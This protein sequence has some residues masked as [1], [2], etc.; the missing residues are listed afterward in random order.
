MLWSKLADNGIPGEIRNIFVYWDAKQTGLKGPS[1]FP[2]SIG[3]VCGK[4]G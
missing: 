2:K 4:G 1:L 3:W